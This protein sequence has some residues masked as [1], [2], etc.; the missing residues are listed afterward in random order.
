MG[1]GRFG[2]ASRAVESSAVVEAASLRATVRAA[3]AARADGPFA[4][5]VA[6][7]AVNRAAME[8]A[9]AGSCVVAEPARA[10][11]CGTTKP[12]GGGGRRAAPATRTA[13]GFNL[14]P[15]AGVFARRAEIA[16]TAAAALAAESSLGSSLGS[17]F[18]FSAFG[19]SALASSTRPPPPVL[20]VDLAVGVTAATEVSLFTFGT[21][22]ASW[23]GGCVALAPWSL[24][25][26]DVDEQDD[27]LPGTLPFS[28]TPLPP[29]PVTAPPP[30]PPPPD[31]V[32]F[33]VCALSAAI[34]EGRAFFLPPSAFA[35]PPDKGGV[36][37]TPEDIF[38]SAVC[39]PRASRAVASPVFGPPLGRTLLFVG[40]K[41]FLSERALVASAAPF[42]RTEDKASVWFERLPA[43]RI[44]S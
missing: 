33:C 10:D 11:R 31:D 21:W 23:A 1:P 5:P 43:K 14:K 15:S 6:A 16:A 13:R 29:A 25:L 30:P 36:F 38:F 42:V 8:P 3:A 2:V 34:V 28:L 7:R 37:L 9:R 17:S 35:A 4:E 19:S 44:F 20:E 26:D 39:P 18:A 24:P 27:F 40:E 32:V 12:A 22:T 41:G